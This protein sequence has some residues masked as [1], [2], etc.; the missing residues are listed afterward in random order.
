MN[1]ISISLSI[2]ELKR[3]TCLEKLNL[4]VL[5]A[6]NYQITESEMNVMNKRI[7]FLSSLSL[8]LE[9]RKKNSTRLI[10]ELTEYD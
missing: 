10:I 3:M 8:L 2:N 9:R 5:R 6:H 7:D 4:K 1:E